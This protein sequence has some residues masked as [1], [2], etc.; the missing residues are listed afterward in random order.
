VIMC[1][2]ADPGKEPMTATQRSFRLP[3]ELD[4]ELTKQAAKLERSRSWLIVEALKLYL[5]KK[6]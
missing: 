5:K 4:E 3:A 1:D 2:T 6:S